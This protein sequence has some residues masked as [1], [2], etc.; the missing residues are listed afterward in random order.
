VGKRGGKIKEGR[1]NDG[2]EEKR[3][4]K[5]GWG[6]KVKIAGRDGG[7]GEDEEKEKQ[8]RLTGRRD[9]LKKGRW[10]TVVVAFKWRKREKTVALSL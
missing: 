4:N 1:G 7:V 10:S 3:R 2:D 6:K 5:K 8:K 9:R